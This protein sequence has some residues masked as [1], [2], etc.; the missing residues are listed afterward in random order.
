MVVFIKNNHHI[1]AMFALIY[2]TDFADDTDY[3]NHFKRDAKS[4][5]F[6]SAQLAAIK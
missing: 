4:T 6:N 3:S 1:D 2:S 5:G